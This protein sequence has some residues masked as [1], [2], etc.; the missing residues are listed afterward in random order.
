MAGPEPIAPPRDEPV[1]GPPS[2]EP[3]PSAPL[4]AT[5][6]AGS[7][8]LY[9]KSGAPVSVAPEHAH[10]AI[11]SGT[12]GYAP[13][14]RVP[15]RMGTDI[16][17]VDADALG[18]A[19]AKYGAKPVTSAQFHEHELQKKYGGTA[20]QA[21]AF[22]AS[23]LDSATLGLSNA[24]IG[25]V[26]GQGA[27]EYVRNVEA[28]NPNA[29]TA[30]DVAGF[31]APIA[32]DVL[33]GG[34]LTPGLVAAEGARAAEKGLVRA[35]AETAILGPTRALSKVGAVAEAGAKALVGSGAE[36][37]AARVAQSIIAG[38]ARGVA[39]GG[40]VGVG[41]EV[42]KQYLQDDPTLTGESLSTAW[43]H[44]ALVGGVLGGA[45][46]GVGGLMSRKAPAAADA[47]ALG[48]DEGAV[49]AAA[50]KES[51]AADAAA[52]T[53]ISQVDDPQKAK[54]LADAWKHR[55]FEGHENM[56]KDASRKVTSTLDEAIEAGRVV[57]MAS[58]GESKSNQMAK[59]V[60][61]S[62]LKPAQK[63]A[64]RVAGDTQEV[65]DHL[66][67]LEMKGGASGSVKRIEGWLQDFRKAPDVE[68]KDPAEL[69]DKIDDFKR[70]VGKEAGFG[71]NVPGREEAT[72]KFNE[73]YEKLRLGLED[74][75]TWGAAAVAQ[76]D[77]NLATSNMI[78]TNGKFLQ[79]FTSQYGSEALTGAPKYIADSAKVN[80][81]VNGLTSA[82]NDTNTRMAADYV[83]KRAQFLDAVTKNYDLPS[84]ALAAVKKE[85]ASLATMAETITKTSNEVERV[86]QLKQIMADERGHSIHGIIGMAIDAVTKPGLTLARLAELEAMKNRVVAKVEKSVGS[87]KS[88]ITGGKPGRAPSME[89]H[90]TY[91]QRRDSLLRAAG[92]PDQMQAH[93]TGT[94]APMGSHAPDTARAFEQASMRAVQYLMQVLP[95][96][97]P[98]RADSLTPQVDMEKWQPNDQQK[99]Q[100]NRQY[101]AA[102]HPEKM[103]HL[104]ADGTITPQH[105]AAL[106]ATKPAMYAMQ[107]KALK[108]ALADLDKPVPTHMQ[109]PVKTFLQLPQLDP[110]TQKLMQSTYAA[111]AAHGPGLKRPMK[112]A[113]NTS[114]N[115]S[116]L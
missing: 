69:F 113:D 114:L 43:V 100:F 35:A 73:L 41:Q 93:L 81:F 57:D 86:N 17:T 23:A 109:A 116:K 6:K 74:E 53:I 105:V 80:G 2:A 106:A 13:G 95:K 84:A 62:S 8:T 30:G 94:A 49:K 61:A 25:A 104:V 15:V 36:N 90:E 79:R 67:S 52:K 22:G 111:P 19:V 47:V 64:L 70:R 45:L 66:N 83:A 55:S 103:L 99:S 65:L 37:R 107:S 14:T 28:A 10:D 48:A 101:D 72:M 68:W 42:G 39:E 97:P 24:A 75:S 5:Q 20:G 40:L 82:A 7:I 50:A 9:D 59:L 3:G 44:G 77:V 29:A 1:I 26:G 27:R 34:T 58:F 51:T 31:V 18:D 88:A 89:T 11:L 12:Y 110:Q 92:N 115:A 98:P 112:M 60:P 78:D 56:L 71:R 96:P 4:P 46:H 32:A 54:L 33:S 16:G 87:V 38:G 63:M 85:R 76:K 102:V 108:A 91:E 21:V